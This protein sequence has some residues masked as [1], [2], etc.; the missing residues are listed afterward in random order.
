MIETASWWAAVQLLGLAA[1]PLAFLVFR[2]LADGGYAFSKVLGLLLLA[3]L[4]WLSGMVGILPNE[5][6][7]ILLLAGLLALGSG[8]IASRNRNALRELIG[9]RWRFFVACDVLFAASLA[10]AA[11]LRSYV[12]EIDGTEKPMDFAFLNAV[13][14]ADSFPP[15]DPWLAGHG[16]SYYYF[17]H[18]ITAMVTKLTGVVPAVGYNL[19]VALTAALA[20]TAVFGLV[21]NL[22]EARAGKVAP[23]VFAGLGVVLLL[24]LANWEGFFEFL[25]VHDLVPHFMY[26]FLNIDGLEGPK[27]SGSWYP[28]E[29][30]FWWR[31]TRIVSGWTIREFPFFSFMLGDLHA[32]VL[33]LPFFLT[34]AG[35]ALALLRAP[36]KLD[37]RAW[38]KDPLALGLSSLL[39]GSL[40]FLNAWDFP[41]MV[42]LVAG[43]ALLA[44]HRLGLS[45]SG[46]RSGLV[47]IGILA[48]L[49]LVLF[50]PFL[51]SFGSAAKFIAPV[52]VTNSPDYVTEGD[53]ASN[54]VHLLLAWGP[55][56]WLA[57]A[58]VAVT[59]L[60]VKPAGRTWL[61]AMT[62]ILVV[63]A[64]WVGAVAF[65]SGPGGLV[66]EIGDRDVAWLSFAIC[67]G[68]LILGGAALLAQ[69]G[70]EEVARRRSLE[71]ALLAVWLGLL[72]VL[73]SELFYVEEF[74]EARIN[75]V[76][77]LSFQAWIL[78]AVGCSYGCFYLW[79]RRP[80]ALAAEVGV[81]LR[82]PALAWRPLAAAS[83]VFVGMAL[84]Y[85][86]V[87]TANRS[88]G[89]TKT[90]TLDGLAY[91]RN[92]ARSEY[93]A[94]KW[95]RENV[96][97]AVVVLEAPGPDWG[98]NSRISWRTG[99]PTVIGWPSHE[100]I[101]RGTWEPQDGR[102]ED[103]NSI[104]ISDDRERVMELLALY[105]VEYIVVGAPE[106]AL[107]G[108]AVNT[109]FAGIAEPVATF[110]TLVIYRVSGI[111]EEV[112]QP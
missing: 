5:R 108:N 29:F 84:V 36:F 102:E 49:G 35:L 16:V 107:Y 10:V 37:W 55:L 12:P 38:A 4:Y 46:A 23:Y 42:A 31:A 103:V 104:Y 17:G 58:F 83:L 2:R 62:P 63:L 101:W 68:L 96:D 75:T 34:A 32:H 67:A 98:E 15:E 92:H 6:W 89:L 47:F 40:I 48:G 44:N 93:D 61:F 66:E 90:Q 109:Q 91:V 41:T 53:M 97:G 70:R 76:F 8:F 43:A 105:D 52:M 45:A 112:G 21:W 51:T 111:T 82:L 69:L 54:P 1:F 80:A 99:L 73:G 60:E 85:P 72:L 78:L 27:D 7:A 26:G 106:V 94:V 110:D 25:A 77:K 28:T 64:C 39:L 81:Q 86:I 79:E 74:A 30:W 88:D 22:L 59:A 71:F 56:F 57:G 87:A 20:A 3:Y 14:R 11:F 33:A 9:R 50:V 19:G 18:L 24:F 65:D 13:L 95:L 100:Y